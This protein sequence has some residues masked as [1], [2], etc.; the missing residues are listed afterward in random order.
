MST[1]V[2][3]APAARSLLRILG[4]AF[5]IAVVVGDTVGV[6]IMRTPGPTAA[7][8]QDPLLIYLVWLAL[9][10]YV[11]MAANTLAELATAIPRTGGLYVYVRRGFGDFPGFVCGWGDFG[12]QAIAIGYL[13]VASSEFLAQALPRLAGREH[14]LGPVLICAFAALNS[15]GLRTSSA[16]A[17]LV[18]LTK[19]VLLAALVVA[20]FA[21]APPGVRAAH[22]ALPHGTAG[23]V[24]L[25]VSMQ[26]VLEVYDGFN[27][28]CY[29][30]EETT[31]P[32]RTVPRALLYGVL[33]VIAVYL[34]VNAALLHVLTPAELGASKLAAG[35]A[36]AKLF[37][38]AAGTAVAL[39]ACAA[40]LGVLNTVMLVAPRILYG[41]SRDGLFVARAGQVTGAGVPLPALWLSAA[42]A[43]AFAALGS[44]ETL[45]AAGAFL[46]AC[47]DLLCN[48]TLFVLR[49]REPLL[50]R[51]YRAFGYPWIPGLVLLSAAALLGVFILGNPRPSLL[52]VGVLLLTYPLFR[53]TR[54]APAVQPSRP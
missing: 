53:L 22:A 1:V 2:P 18:S 30:S 12:I 26:I 27:A 52:A 3:G 8:L 11:L 43:M 54:R 16:A 17:Q 51:P 42:A 32:G 38:P 41:M 13:A 44:F 23:F 25:I 4:L 7:R 19:I 35:S 33:L 45:Y 36:L 31:D 15:V 39:M 37:G 28:A 10:V 29:F 48:A 40:A 14:L 21:F 20:A 6:G 47:T 50:A 9:G 5:G 24:A 49:R 34:A 46:A